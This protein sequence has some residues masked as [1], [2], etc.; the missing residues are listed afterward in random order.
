MKDKGTVISTEDDF[1]RVKVSCL[2][3]CQGCSASSLCI[4]TKNA[5]GLL[6][7]RNPLR[8]KKGDLVQIS[9]PESHYSR[10]LI[11]LFGVLLFA[12]LMGMGLGYFVSPVLPLSSLES[13]LC[14]IALGVVLAGSGLS[15]RFK[16]I[17][18]KSLYPEITEIL[19]KGG[20][21]G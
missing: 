13:G 4:G 12:M 15:R 5:T 3:A 16:S 1:A 7:V 19:I 2:E 14:G 9:I 6:S 11:L 20:S 10:A 18:N 8:A 17:N 21:Y